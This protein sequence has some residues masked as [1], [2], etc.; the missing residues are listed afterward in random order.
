MRFR[1]LTTS[2]IGVEQ[3]QPFGAGV[4]GL[5]LGNGAP[6][7]RRM[8]I[9][10][11]IVLSLKASSRAT[12]STICA[13]RIGQRSFRRSSSRS[14]FAVASV[15]DVNPHLSIRM[16]AAF[17]D[18]GFRRRP[19]SHPGRPDD[20]MMVGTHRQSIDPTGAARLDL[21]TWPTPSS[22]ASAFGCDGIPE[23]RRQAEPKYVDVFIILHQTNYADVEIV[24]LTVPDQRVCRRSRFF[25]TR[26]CGLT[27][28]YSNNP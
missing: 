2:G 28:R 15:I 23:T 20:R 26:D 16:Q 22:M 7:T 25:H 17:D 3:G 12:C 14:R 19:K 6:G 10:P 8:W 13:T 27:S 9:G 21:G 1:F 24:R 18:A 4:A 5:S 11:G